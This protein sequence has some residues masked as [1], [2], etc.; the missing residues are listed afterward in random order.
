MY[1]CDKCHVP[2]QVKPTMP[3][4]KTCYDRGRVSS[5]TLCHDRAYDGHINQCGYGRGMV[6]QHCPNDYSTSMT[7]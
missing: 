4:R 6:A 2:S 7:Q 3:Y 1:R 5:W